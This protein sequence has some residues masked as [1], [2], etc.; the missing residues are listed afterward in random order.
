MFWTCKVQV[1]QMNKKV[2]LT[3]M[4]NYPTSKTSTTSKAPTKNRYLFNWREGLHFGHGKVV[5]EL[6][7]AFDCILG[8]FDWC[9]F[10]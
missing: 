8:A 6:P 7:V 4:K 1:E 3:R 5:I 2:D 9:A 10:V